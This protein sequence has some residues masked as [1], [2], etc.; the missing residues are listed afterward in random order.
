[1]TA[2]F[3]N[4]SKKSEIKRLDSM[5][6]SGLSHCV[7]L[8]STY[9]YVLISMSFYF[10]NFKKEQ[11]HFD[12]SSYTYRGQVNPVCLESASILSG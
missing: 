4:I 9:E 5:Y 1:M 6:S 12:D 2:C 3:V 10:I 11:I 7:S 8:W